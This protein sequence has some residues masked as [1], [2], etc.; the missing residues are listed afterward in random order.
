MFSL[1]YHF[2][3]KS[4]FNVSP[5]QLHLVII[6]CQLYWCWKDSFRRPAA[7]FISAFKIA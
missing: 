1:K 6:N 2:T 3:H 4:K 7:L 5:T